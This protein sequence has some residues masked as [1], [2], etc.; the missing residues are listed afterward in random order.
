VIV[1]PINYLLFREPVSWRSIAGTS[2]AFAGVALIF[3]A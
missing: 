1:I 3:L 2:I